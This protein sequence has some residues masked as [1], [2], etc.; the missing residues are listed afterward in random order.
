MHLLLY[1]SVLD[2]V[3]CLNFGK[4][5]FLPQGSWLSILAEPLVR[6]SLNL[7]EPWVRGLVSLDE[8]LV[9]FREPSRFVDPYMWRTVGSWLFIPDEP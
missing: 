1:V 7:D 9:W 5:V 6:G 4:S 3:F 8:P 2:L